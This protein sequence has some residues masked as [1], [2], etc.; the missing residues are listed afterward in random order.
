MSLWPRKLI[1]CD[2]VNHSVV[3]DELRIIRV[4]VIVDKTTLFDILHP[5]QLA[6]GDTLIPFIEKIVFISD[7]RVEPDSL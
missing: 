4:E 2:N 1:D 5:S 6:A 3:E 7:S